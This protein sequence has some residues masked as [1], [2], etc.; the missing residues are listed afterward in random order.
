MVF[1]EYTKQRILFWFNQGKKPPSISC[2]LLEEGIVASRQG[3]LKF[4]RVYKA[5]GTIARRPGSGFS[6]K[7]NDELK[8]LIDDRMKDDDE[9]T[10]KQLG[11]A[12]AN[13]GHAVSKS[14]ILRCRRNLGWTYRGSAYCQL[15]RET[16]REKRLQWAIQYREEA[17]GD[18]FQDV[19][20][21]DECTVQLETHRRFCC[22]RKGEPP[23]NKPR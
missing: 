1:S 6:S 14:T 3:I 5:S 16:N 18:G 11:Q 8:Q 9:T 15:I 22:R 7:V 13:E 19:L 2:L 4:L 21:T 23:R 12:L 20:W 17:T 10:A